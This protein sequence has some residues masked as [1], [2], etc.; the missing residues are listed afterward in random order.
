M[1]RSRGWGQWTAD[2]SGGPPLRASR[3]P[4]RAMQSAGSRTAGSRGPWKPELLPAFSNW[5]S[6]SSPIS[7]RMAAQNGVGMRMRSPQPRWRQPHR[8]GRRAQGSGPGDSGRHFMRRSRANE[9]AL[10]RRYALR[11]AL[12]SCSLCPPH[13]LCPCQAPRRPSR[14]AGRRARNGAYAGRVPIPSTT[15]PRRRTARPGNGPR[16]NGLMPGGPQQAASRLLDRNAGPNGPGSASPHTRSSTGSRS[17][18]QPARRWSH[19][20]AP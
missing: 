2:V 12:C 13:S 11:E 6:T 15:P 17:H 10:T 16:S 3:R 8:F 14:T 9:T 19:P 20:P 7:A 4:Y 5:R 18:P 1:R